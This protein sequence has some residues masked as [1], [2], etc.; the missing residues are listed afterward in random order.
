MR[1][2][3]ELLAFA[4]S[5]THGEQLRGPCPIHRSASPR[6]RI[7][8]VHLAGNAFR[9]FKCGSWG[10]QLD[11]W[12]ALTKT[13]LHAATI[14]LCRRLQIDV[15]WICPKQRSAISDDS[16]LP[17]QRTGTRSQRTRFPNGIHPRILPRSHRFM[18]PE[19]PECQ[20]APNAYA[21]VFKI[22]PKA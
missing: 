21:S 20:G 2:V 11:L 7:F 6:S 19:C 8:P 10:K 16:S 22:T 13:D 18:S 1:N 9:C 15:P 17:E 12:A 5:E 4:P 3:L 14:E